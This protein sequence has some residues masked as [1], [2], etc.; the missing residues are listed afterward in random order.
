MKRVEDY[1]RKMMKEFEMIDLGLLKYFLEIQVR[2]GFFFF[3]S[4]EKC[5][6]DLF[7]K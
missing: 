4:Q 1:K 7:K 6:K 3:L 5:T 2:Q